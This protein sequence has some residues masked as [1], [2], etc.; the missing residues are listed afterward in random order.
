MSNVKIIM[1]N[2]VSGCD[3]KPSG[4]KFGGETVWWRNGLRRI[5]RR[6][7]GHANQLQQN[8]LSSYKYRMFNSMFNI[9]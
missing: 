6:P 8:V 3:E 4:E 9:L 2:S 5:V 1:S 7:N